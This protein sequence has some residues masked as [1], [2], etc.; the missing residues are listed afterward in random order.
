[1]STHNHGVLSHQIAH[2]NYM[3]VITDPAHLQS[4][5]YLLTPEATDIFRHHERQ[6]PHPFDDAWSCTHCSI[7][8]SNYVNRQKALDHVK[9]A[10]VLR[11]STIYL[12]MHVN[13]L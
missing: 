3:H 5:W 2:A 13:A 12:L 7:H 1:M 9:N 6:Y 10:Y 8:F 4:F 11:S